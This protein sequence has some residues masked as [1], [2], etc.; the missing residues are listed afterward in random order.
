MQS[1]Q[2]FLYLIAIMICLYY[3]IFMSY[4]YSLDLRERVLSFIEDGHSQ[5]E[6]GKVFK[7]PRQTIYNWLRLKAGTGHLRM[8]RSGQRCPSKLEEKALREAVDS[9]RD[10]FGSLGLFSMLRPVAFIVL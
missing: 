5:K 6:A 4:G 1:F 7:V 2:Y 8:R 3:H 9:Y 10:Y